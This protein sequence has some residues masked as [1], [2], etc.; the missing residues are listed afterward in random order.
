MKDEDSGKL[1]QLKIEDALKELGQNGISELQDL[2]KAALGCDFPSEV[3]YAPSIIAR[4]E[5][6]LLGISIPRFAYRFYLPEKHGFVNCRRLQTLIN[7]AEKNVVLDDYTTRTVISDLEGQK[8]IVRLSSVREILESPRQSCVSDC[9]L[10]P[11]ARFDKN[12][13][14][15]LDTNLDVAYG[16]R[17]QAEHALAFLGTPYVKF[18]DLAGGVC[19]ESACFM[20]TALLHN[21]AKSVYGLAEIT[22]FA[23]IEEKT[24]LSI[25]GL[26]L[27]D[28]TRY[29]T[30]V[31]L[32][33]IQQMP[34]AY[35]AGKPIF[36]RL[37][38]RAF[39]K[40]VRAYLLSKM[41]VILPVDMARLA[42]CTRKANGKFETTNRESVYDT[43][44]FHVEAEEFNFAPSHSHALVLIGCSR[45]PDID[46][47]K[48]VFHD[49]AYW[50]FMHAPCRLFD[51][52]GRYKSPTEAEREDQLMMSVTP[53]AVKLPLLSWR[54]GDADSFNHG[55]YWLSTNLH[56]NQFS[57]Y[58]LV[59]AK[60]GGNFL[61]TQL[62]R[63]KA[64]GLEMYLR[65]DLVESFKT[66]LE[67]CVKQLNDT[68]GWETEHWVWAEVFKDSIWIW[69][70]EKEAPSR[71]DMR[72]PLHYQIKNYLRSVLK[73][74]ANGGVESH[75]VNQGRSGAN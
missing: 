2:C 13:Y 64:C 56:E 74:T 49:P 43:N 5:A 61:L 40:V 9:L 24:L 68:D 42:G 7:H 25:S 51:D 75:P 33:A 73:L 63:I 30:Q 60:D 58:P 28:M 36:A 50:P 52:V 3:R 17:L 11:P 31:K 1:N 26:Y 55:L 20:A 41:P 71:R 29:F 27:D 47:N 48:I 34:F 66:E 22:A 21:Y 69:D 19:A 32:Q 53:E 8:E 72:A 35:A 62:K 45:D 38:Q 65:P 10:T 12:K 57:E 37:R 44:G 70:A 39:T 46:K 18:I 14:A 4:S 54:N 67:Q 15:I 16:E 59:V 6:Q 23:K